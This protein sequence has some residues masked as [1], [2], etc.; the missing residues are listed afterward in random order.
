MLVVANDDRPDHVRALVGD[1]SR[2]GLKAKFISTP[3]EPSPEEFL[4]DYGGELG[5]EAQPEG[6]VVMNHFPEVPQPLF[7]GYEEWFAAVQ[8]W[9]PRAIQPDRVGMREL[10][11]GVWAA[12]TAHVERGAELRAPCWLGENTYVS[13]GA[14]IGPEAVLEPG[15]F[16]EADAEISHTVIGPS[17]FVGRY[18]RLEHALALGNRIIN[19]KTD[20]ET[21]VQDPFLLCSWQR[22]EPEA[23]RAGWHE[24][25]LELCTRQKDEHPLLWKCFSLK[26]GS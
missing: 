19:W 2:W 13:A 1:G 3:R 14:V 26:R 15:A 5:A 16:V 24:R 25:I 21:E 12:L 8:A 4:S 9:M 10:Q 18:V 22:V 17:T 7:T 11:P 6:I 23:A 20:A